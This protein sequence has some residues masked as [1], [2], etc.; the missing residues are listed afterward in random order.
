[1]ID[2]DV[3][4]SYTAGG[5]LLAMMTIGIAFSA[6]MPALDR[7]NR[8]YF[9]MFFSLLFLYTGVIFIDMIL[10][11][12]PAMVR[13]L[14]AVLIMEHLFFSVL[15]LFPTFFLLHSCGASI[16]SSALLRACL[17][18]WSLFFILLIASPFSDAFYTV[19]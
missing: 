16:K 17:A 19:S 5:A 15:T 14:T 6:F 4:A 8:R 7:W 9:I 18:L 2:W 1:M 12:N 10:Y 13:A 11:D 3:L